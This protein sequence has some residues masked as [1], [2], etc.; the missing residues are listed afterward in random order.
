VYVGTTN[1][2]VYASGDAGDHWQR[3]PGTLP[4]ILS[5]TA[6]AF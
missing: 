6:A 3:L 1:G 4:P 2:Q 5:V